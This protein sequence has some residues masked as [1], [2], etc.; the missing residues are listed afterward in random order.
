M[1]CRSAPSA[2]IFIGKSKT[3]RLIFLELLETQGRKQTVSGTRVAEKSIHRIAEGRNREIGRLAQTLF[4]AAFDEDRST[5]CGARTTNIAPPVADDI[6]RAKV[7]FQ[8]GCCSQDH[9]RS[10]LAA[11]ARI[12][13]T[14]ARMITNF[15]AIKRWKRQLHFCMHR[16]DRFATL[17][18]ATYVGLVGDHNQKKFCCLKSRAAVCNVVVEFEIVDASRRMGLTV[19]DDGPIEH[20][21]AI[22]EDGVSRYFVLS[23]FVSATFRAGWETH[24]CHTTA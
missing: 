9:P 16:L 14:L 22:Q 8:P 12:A 6:T 15:D 19:A 1:P 18:A 21:I 2:K 11:I 13:V 5:T 4:V 10:R 24:R 23:H 17:S 20:A 7:N 3:C